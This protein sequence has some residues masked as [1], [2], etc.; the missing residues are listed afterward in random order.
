MNFKYHLH[1]HQSSGSIPEKEIE[2]N[3]QSKMMGRGL[4][5][6]AVFWAW[7]DHPNDCG[8]VRKTDKILAQMV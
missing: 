4:L 5:W 3:G 1:Q 2:K 8:Y 7:H 6:N